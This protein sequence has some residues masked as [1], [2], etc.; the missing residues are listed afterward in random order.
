VLKLNSI[1][2]NSVHE[3]AATSLESERSDTTD[4]DL[5]ARFTAAPFTALVTALTAPG[6]TALGALPL[7]RKLPLARAARVNP[8][9]SDTMP[10]Q[11]RHFLSTP[12]ECTA[13]DR[14]ERGWTSP[15]RWVSM[16]TLL[17]QKRSNK[18]TEA[19]VRVSSKL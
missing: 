11:I 9:A 7:A 5:T 3:L 8:T 19:K 10:S 15:G 17:E 6:T 16:A 12:V 1:E 2:L 13:L 14:N 18:T 4:G